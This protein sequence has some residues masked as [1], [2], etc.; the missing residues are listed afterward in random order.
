[1]PQLGESRASA[2]LPFLQVALT[3]FVIDRPA[4]MAAFL[5]QVAHESGQL[6]F[7]EELW[8][9]TSAQ[10]R[11]EPPGTLANKLGNTEPGDGKRFK[12]RGPIQITGR[13][14]YHRYGDLL[15]IDL[16]TAPERAAAPDVTFRIAGLFWTRNG[17]NELADLAT[18]DSFRTITRRING[19]LNGLADRQSFYASAR[20]VFGVEE[21][22]A[23]AAREGTEDSQM[24]KTRKTQS[25]KTTSAAKS[26][27]K[28]AKG[29][30]AVSLHIGLNAVSPAAYSGWSGDLVACEFDANDMAS[31]AK[32]RGMKSTILLTKKATRANVLKSVRAAAKSL[33]AG[34]LF[35]V[36]Y[37]GHGGQMPDVS[38]DEPDQKDETWC[39]FDGELIDDEVYVELSRFAEGVRVLVLSDSCHSGS[40]TRDRMP[41]TTDPVGR[42]KMMPP[43]VAMR[44]YRDHQPFYDKLQHALEPSDRS[45]SSADPDAVLAALAVRPRLTDVAA[46]CKASVILIS[47]CQDNQTSMDGDHNGAFTE[48]LLRVWDNG[49]YKGN[50]SK[51]HAAIKAGMSATQTPNLFTL[52]PVTAF[53]AET[54]F[55]V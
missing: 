50:Y 46:A 14:N 3:E 28:P 26:A 33:K 53:V 1:M 9:P 6:R 12:G 2:L 40:V 4:R 10:R 32:S 19:G 55:S 39:L 31:I 49:G 23:Q 8:G 27:K 29:A 7:M 37:S 41:A 25:R 44:V 11:Y 18:D 5:A 48:Q 54:P 20:T 52:G 43:A 47:G 42:S 38:G 13:D 36:T 15:G 30:N 45:R 35:F 17:L 16:L 24:A 22:A 51:F 21:G 34:D